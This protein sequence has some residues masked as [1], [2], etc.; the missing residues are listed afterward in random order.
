[1][2]DYQK[3]AHWRD[4]ANKLFPHQVGFTCPPHDFDAAP[5]DFLRMA[6]PTVGVHGRMLPH[7]ER[8]HRHRHRIGMKDES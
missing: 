6:P 1:M 7:Y 2:N 3:A 4:P 5:S 8:M